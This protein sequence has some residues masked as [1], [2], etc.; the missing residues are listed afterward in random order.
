[1]YMG[2]SGETYIYAICIARRARMCT[3][4]FILGYGV[5]K[6]KTSSIQREME[7]HPKRMHGVRQNFL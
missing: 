3:Q 7:G 5:N 1:M 6:N 4:I 2:F